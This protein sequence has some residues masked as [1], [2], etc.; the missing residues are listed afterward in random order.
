MK[1][2]WCDFH[3]W[4]MLEAKILPESRA[5]AEASVFDAQITFSDMHCYN[6]VYRS[7]MALSACQR[8]WLLCTSISPWIVSFLH[9]PGIRKQ[10]LAVVFL[11][12]FS[13]SLRADTQQHV[14]TV[15]TWLWTFPGSILLQFCNTWIGFCPF[16]V[17]TIK[18]ISQFSFSSYFEDDYAN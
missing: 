3:T 1:K 15:I 12:I 10:D 16:F 7:Y 13:S 8:Q 17:S 6:L 4:E 14:W 11:I 18:Q 5:E 2:S 9:H